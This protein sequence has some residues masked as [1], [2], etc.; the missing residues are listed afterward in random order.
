MGQSTLPKPI[1]PL[2]SLYQPPLEMS[3]RKKKK[4]F[5]AEDTDVIQKWVRVRVRVRARLG[6]G[7][8]CDSGVLPMGT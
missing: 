6:L 7:L 8:Y 3:E 4:M 2:K 1:R 5:S